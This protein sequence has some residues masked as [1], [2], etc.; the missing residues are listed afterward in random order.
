ME[1]DSKLV[2]ITIKDTTSVTWKGAT[3]EALNT[4]VV[5]LPSALFIEI[6]KIEQR[7]VPGMALRIGERISCVCF[8]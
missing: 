2:C 7:Q 5:T 3:G 6:F 1:G 4:T 8:L